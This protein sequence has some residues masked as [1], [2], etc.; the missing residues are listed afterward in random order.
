[1]G[2]ARR[3]KQEY[4]HQFEQM[5]DKA[6]RAGRGWDEAMS[7][8]LTEFLAELPDANEANRAFRRSDFTAKDKKF[9]GRFADFYWRSRTDRLFGLVRGF[10]I[11]LTVSYLMKFFLNTYPEPLWLLLVHGLMMLK[12]EVV[13]ALFDNLPAPVSRWWTLIVEYAFGTVSL[14]LLVRSFGLGDSALEHWA[15]GILFAMIPMSDFIKH[16]SAF[17]KVYR[18]CRQAR[19]TTVQTS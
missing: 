16:R 8:A 13:N 9:L 6:L 10:L 11:L 2:S 17:R 7:D 14:A 5:L 12:P 18:A 15:Y 4:E 19:S 3:R 1:M